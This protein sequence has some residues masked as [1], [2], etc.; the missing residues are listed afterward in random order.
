MLLGVVG[1]VFD[2]VLQI[3]DTKEQAVANLHRFQLVGL[4]QA[5]NGAAADAERS[6]RALN[7]NEQRWY[8]GHLFACQGHG[9]SVMAL[10]S[11]FK[12]V[13]CW[14]R[15]REEACH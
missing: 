12:A 5:V 3:A 6:D 13:G 9:V 4:D 2:E 1:E 15:E 8:H 10:A 14:G 7:V 11:A